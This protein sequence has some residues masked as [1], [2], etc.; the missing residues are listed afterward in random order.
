MTVEQIAHKAITTTEDQSVIKAA[1]TMDAEGIGVL[2]VEDDPVAG[3]VTDREIALAVAEHDGDLSN[4]TVSDIMTEDT[5]TLE[6]TDESLEA[7][8]TMAEAGIRRIPI[9]DDSG[10]LTGLVSLDDVVALTGEQLED[11]ATTIEK[12][13]PEYEP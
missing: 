3:I 7:A 2:V 10:A 11:V 8:R 1:E 4:V 13:S 9:V 6:E 12:Q 5:H